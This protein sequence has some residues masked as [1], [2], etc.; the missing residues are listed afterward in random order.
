MSAQGHTPGD[1][2]PAEMATVYRKYVNEGPA[3]FDLAILASRLRD[4]L[5]PVQ[6]ELLRICDFSKYHDPRQ[7]GRYGRD[8][9][10]TET[11]GFVRRALRLYD[12][13]TYTGL[14]DP[15]RDVA[16]LRECLAYLVECF[17]PPDPHDADQECPDCKMLVRARAVLSRTEASAPGGKP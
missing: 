2:T 15:E 9:N 1:A 12:A 5:G 17:G 6:E 13:A 4:F 11:A 3:G 8:M 7:G 10:D 16:E 14:P